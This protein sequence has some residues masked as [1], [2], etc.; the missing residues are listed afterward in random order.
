LL[1]Q[2]V[3]ALGIELINYDGRSGHYLLHV[4]SIIQKKTLTASGKGSSFS[5]ILIPA[6]GLK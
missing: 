6:S 2:A 4:I 3:D 5:I 1:K